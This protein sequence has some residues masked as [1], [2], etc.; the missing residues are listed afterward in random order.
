MPTIVRDGI[1]LVY[2]V[3]GTGTPA[4]VFVHGWTC[5]RSFFAAQAQAGLAAPASWAASARVKVSR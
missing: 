2:D 5:D 3:R 4:F 1:K